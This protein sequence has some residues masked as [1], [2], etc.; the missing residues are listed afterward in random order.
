METLPLTNHSLPGAVHSTIIR[1]LQNKPSSSRT[2]R[3][4]GPSRTPSEWRWLDC[5]PVK[6]PN[7]RSAPESTPQARPLAPPASELG[8]G[9]HPKDGSTGEVH[10]MARRLVRLRQPRHVRLHQNLVGRELHI[11][12]YARR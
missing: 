6:E 11:F 8:Q 5:S 3:L 9:N 10:H 7:L 12:Q 2:P 4:T 1:F